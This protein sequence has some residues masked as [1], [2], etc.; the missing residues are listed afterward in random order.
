MELRQLECFC[1][2]ADLEN[3]SKAA[4]RM[5][6]TQ[7]ALSSSI[8]TLEKELDIQLFLRNGKR[9]RLSQQG[10]L[11]F[12]QAQRIL[13]ERDAF[14]VLCSS[15][16]KSESIRLRAAVASD[17]LPEIIRGFRAKN[18]DI[19][20]FILQND[21]ASD[22][23]DLC[24][25]AVPVQKIGVNDT[26]L[27]R[28][29]IVLAVPPTHEWAQRSHIAL[30]ELSGKPIISLRTGQHLRDL[31]DSFFTSAKVQPHRFIECDS[32]AT[33]RQLIRSGLGA[34]L[35]PEISWSSIRN[36][37]IRFI[38]ISRPVCARCIVVRLERDDAAAKLL[39]SY[40]IEFFSGLQPTAGDEDGKRIMPDESPFPE[41]SV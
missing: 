34:A 22:P 40:L 28:E 15:Q 1:A 14:L 13:K 19:E 21:S 32:P 9:V 2:A 36:D 25:D 11:L 37:G 20:L 41:D 4:D 26:V 35:V 27:L 30:E 39:R 7:P 3:F 31:E 29:D 23:Y 17:L 6:M 12:A 33:L 10:K 18:P 24:L 16:K 5:H 38:P 8:Q